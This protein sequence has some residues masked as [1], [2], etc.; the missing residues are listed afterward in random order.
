MSVQKEEKEKIKKYLVS[1]FDEACKHIIND[2]ADQ[3]NERKLLEEQLAKTF[4][5]VLPE[6]FVNSSEL[7]Y[8][9]VKHFSYYGT[10]SSDL[11]QIYRSVMT[12]VSLARARASWNETQWF[13][14][15]C[16]DSNG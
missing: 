8:N 3:E 14:K 4:W 9:C 12:D 5:L 13:I 2:G 1:L 10:I 6:D 11:A 16:E 7:L 15:L